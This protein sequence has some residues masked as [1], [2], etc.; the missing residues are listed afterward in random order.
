MRTHEDIRRRPFAG[1]GRT[2]WVR[3]PAGY[4]L[5]LGVLFVAA[6]LVGRAVGPVPP[7]M[8]PGWSPPREESWRHG[9]GMTGMGE[10]R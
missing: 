9:S 5:L 3:G 10:S 1:E 8:R 4:L 2:A 6:L 7:E